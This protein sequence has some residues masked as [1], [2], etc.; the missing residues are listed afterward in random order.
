LQSIHPVSPVLRRIKL[1]PDKFVLNLYGNTEL[2][3]GVKDILGA[4]TQAI[5][6]PANSGLSHGAG[7]AA[8]ISDA[9]GE[10]MEAACEKIISKIGK[11][12]T[13]YAVPTIAGNLPYKYIIHAVGPRMGDGDTEGLLKDTIINVMKVGLKKNITSIAFP[14]IGT[15]IFG[16]PKETCAK[17]FISALNKFWQADE[18]RKV[19]LVWICLTIDDFPYFEKA[20]KQ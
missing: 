8:I 7:L 20:I 15:G 13:S 16:I 5:V 12:P 1:E 17:A 2:I 18:N 14:A 6:N 9:A 11:V 3:V 10:E 4:P 19:N